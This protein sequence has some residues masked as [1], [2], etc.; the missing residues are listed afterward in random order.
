MLFAIP[1]C[2]SSLSNHFAKAP[3]IMLWDNQTN[4]KRILERPQSSSC[5]GHKHFWRKVL[6][7]NQVDA[8]VVRSIGSNMLST[9]FKLNVRVLSAPRGF[10]VESFDEN[11]LTPVTKIEFARP[12][13]KKNKA[14]CS[15]QSATHTSAIGLREAFNGGGVTGQLT[16]TNKLSPRAINHLA[17]VFKLSDQPEKKQ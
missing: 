11:H 13:A 14:S 16:L 10:S 8:V 3:Q 7:D 15:S 17:K 5:C 6:Q 4:T 2:E 9:L 12:S 1:C